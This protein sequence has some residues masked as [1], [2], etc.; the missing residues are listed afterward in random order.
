VNRHWTVRSKVLFDKEKSS[1][2]LKFD[3]V[4]AYYEES[5]LE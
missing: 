2:G 4:E 5:F 1:R 3:I